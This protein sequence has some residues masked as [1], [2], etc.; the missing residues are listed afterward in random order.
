MLYEDLT[1]LRHSNGNPVIRVYNDSNVTYGNSAMQG[2]TI[3]INIQK[4]SGAIV[5]F[6]IV[7]KEANLAGIHVR[8]GS[9]CN[10]GGVSSYLEW[11]PEELLAAYDEGH[12][13]SK[14]LSEMFGK[15]LGVVRISLGAMSNEEDIDTFSRF[16]RETYID[17]VFVEDEPVTIKPAVVAMPMPTDMPMGPLSALPALNRPASIRSMVIPKSQLARDISTTVVQVGNFQDEYYMSKKKSN[18]WKR[19]SCEIPSSTKSRGSAMRRLGFSLKNVMPRFQSEHL[20]N[21]QATVAE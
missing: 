5:S 12:R 8:G 9:L 10:P 13:C 3:A 2:G 11:S 19:R 1:A 6:Q 15:Q 4:P 18:D 20:M 7:E 14:P 17:R 16:V 21:R